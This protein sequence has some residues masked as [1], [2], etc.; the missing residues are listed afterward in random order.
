MEQEGRTNMAMKR[1]VLGLFL[2][3]AVLSGQ[4]AGSSGDAF[5][6]AIRDNDLTRLRAILKDGGDPNVV[7]ARG[8]ATS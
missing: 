6:A 5:Y 1:I 7:D 8:G 4:E 2:C 3:A